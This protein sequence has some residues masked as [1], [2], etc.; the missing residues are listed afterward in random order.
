[1]KRNCPKK[2]RGLAGFALL[3]A[4][5]T[6]PATL[7][8]D[9]GFSG[10]V[11][12][13]VGNV[14]ADVEILIIAPITSSEPVR[15]LATVRTD[16]QGKF[17]VERLQAGAYQIAAIKRGYRTYIGQVNTRVDRW[18]QLVLQPQTRLDADGV[19]LPE[20]DAWALRLPR[21]NILRETEAVLPTFETRPS[22]RPA[23][24]DLPVSLQVDQLFKVATDLQRAPQDES[25]VQGIETRL[26]V[27][28][29][30]GHR[31]D[32]SAELHREQLANSKF[33]DGSAP[34]SR[35]SDGLSAKF[36]YETSVDTRISV[37]AEY[38]SRGARWF[39][40]DGVAP[41]LNH[42][43]ESWRGAVG[44]E[45]RFADSTQLLVGL[46]YASSALRLPDAEFYF[47]TLEPA[48]GNQA[49]EGFGRLTYHGQSG[50]HF[51]LDFN[52]RHLDL[53]AANL[54]ASSGRALLDF[55]GQAGWTGDIRA[56]ETRNLAQR[57]SLIYGIGYRQAVHDRDEDASLLT[58]HLGGLLRFEPLQLQWIATYY[59]IGDWN[60]GSGATGGPWETR[61]RLGYEAALEMSL[62]NNL[63]LS[64]SHESH[65]V[66]A[67][68]IESPTAVIGPVYLT[69]GNATLAQNRLALTREI[70]GLM[71]FAEFGQGAI[72]GSVAAA[73]PY[74]LPFQRI[75]DRDL[76][77]H[78]GRVGLRFVPQGTVV[79]LELREIEESRRANPES[80][81]GQRLVELTLSQDLIQREDL[82]RWRFLM[83]L[84]MA[85]LTAGDPEDLRQIFSADRLDT[86]DGRLS[87]GL[88]LEF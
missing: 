54:Y 73:L 21:R 56:R 61:R 53:S 86:T 27:A 45:K 13:T 1:M 70:G 5:L 22:K 75:A 57:F 6:G 18:I 48:P 66:M 4:L 87:A 37:E 74:D 77:Y 60:A 59:G 34:A 67:N 28:V 39:P 51:E 35:E 41:A 58:P 43:Q 71:L 23:I 9:A 31:G 19:P 52:V 55:S 38:A 10:A 44:F 14:L 76:H 47:P 11:Q 36:S 33:F 65:P 25:V 85:E 32:V 15:P 80:E 46:D 29:P 63:T 82:G 24:S 26:S 72:E 16:F 42:K 83:G 20:D 2:R 68:R 49:I 12:D 81:S 69:D 7:G 8:A 62:A 40:Q 64:G 50:R 17:L 3:A 88:S 78:N 79:T 30:L 84:S